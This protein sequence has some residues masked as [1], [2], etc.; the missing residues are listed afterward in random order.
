MNE[1]TEPERV[2]VE[3]LMRGVE[4]RAAARSTDA[5]SDGTQWQAMQGFIREALDRRDGRKQILPILLDGEIDWRLSTYQRITSHRPRLG[6]VVAFM[7]RY[8]V[9]PAVRWL[10]QFNIENFRRQRGFNDLLLAALEL[11][12]ER[13]ERLEERLEKGTGDSPTSDTRDGD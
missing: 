12:Q 2:D 7:K 13:I 1:H 3:S 11:Q 4:Q 5:D 6:K 8:L 10:H 9:L